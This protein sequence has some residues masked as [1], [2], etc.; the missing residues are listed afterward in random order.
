M[1]SVQR[2]ECDT[3]YMQRTDRNQNITLAIGS[4]AV[5]VFCS[6]K[7]IRPADTLFAIV[8]GLSCTYAHSSHNLYV[9]SVKRCQQ[10]YKSTCINGKS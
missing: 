9:D 10:V 8:S 2:K 1:Q 4:F 7:R 6:Y 5:A 3:C